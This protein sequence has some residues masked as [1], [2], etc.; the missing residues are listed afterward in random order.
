M[1][2]GCE[3]SVAAPLGGRKNELR[4]ARFEPFRGRDA[5]EKNLAGCGDRRSGPVFVNGFAARG[6]ASASRSGC[7]AT[8]RKA[9]EAE[10]EKAQ[11]TPQK[12]PPYQ[13]EEQAQVAASA[14]EVVPIC[15]AAV[16]HRSSCS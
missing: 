15:R 10:G 8:G 14:T 2:M 3:V 12:Y 11:E 16:G 4:P 6:K 5:R 9:Q 1:A 7:C 13:S